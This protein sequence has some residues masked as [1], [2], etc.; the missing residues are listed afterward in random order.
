[1]IGALGSSI[2]ISIAT[3]IIRGV[4]MIIQKMLQTISI[5]LFIILHQLSRGVFF[6]SITGML[7]IR[8]IVVFD[9]VISKTLVIYLYLIPN[10]LLRFHIF[11]SSFFVKSLSI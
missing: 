1:M 5:H 3:M 8:D 10:V 4:K 9:L 7:L 11:K 2:L 6:I